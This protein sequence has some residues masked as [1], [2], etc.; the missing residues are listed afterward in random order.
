MRSMILGVSI[1]FFS[2]VMFLVSVGAGAAVAAT[3]ACATEEP[4]DGAWQQVF[5]SAA[6]MDIVIV[7]LTCEAIITI[8]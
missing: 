3:G 2:I 7:A 1:V 8:I 6:S 5:V 4:V